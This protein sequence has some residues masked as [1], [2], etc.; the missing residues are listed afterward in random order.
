MKH[1][2]QLLSKR[3]VVLSLSCYTKQTVE[4]EVHTLMNPVGTLSRAIDP[5]PINVDALVVT[6]TR[7]W[8]KD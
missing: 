1:P 4:V 6:E 5:I 8:F 7:D 2:P 3:A